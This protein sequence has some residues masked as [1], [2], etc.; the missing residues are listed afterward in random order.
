[1]KVLLAL[2]FFIFAAIQLGLLLGILHY[3]K[4]ESKSKPNPYWVLALITSVT[5]LAFFAVGL[6]NTDDIQRVPPIF[7]PANTLF[8]AAAILQGLFFYSFNHP[9][10]KSLKWA[11]GVSIICYGIFFEYL[12]QNWTFEARTI[13]VAST[14]A[15]I[16]AWQIRE[17]RVVNRNLG[18]QQLRYFQYAAIG[19][20]LFLAPRL[21]VL[22]G[23]SH[24]INKMEQLPQ[25]LIIFTFGQI[26]MNTLSFIAIWGYWSEKLAI[27]NRQTESENL[28]YKKLLDERETLISSLLKANKSSTT[29]ALTA[30]I[31][32]EINQPLGA[33][34]INSE[35]LQ[36][37]ISEETVD[38]EL[39]KRL[40]DDIS[41]DNMRAARIIRILKTIFS[42]KYD[43]VPDQV[44]AAEVIESVILL[45]K[46][47][48]S[49]KQIRVEVD[50]PNS[51]NIPM[52][53]GEAQQIF[54]NLINNSVQAFQSGSK[55][56][57]I[58]RISGT[59]DS[60][61]IRIRSEDNGPGVTPERVQN[62]FDL[63][64]GSKREGMGLGLWLCEYIISRH[65]G[66]I[67][68][69]STYQGGAAFEIT[70]S[71]TE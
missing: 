33:I 61:K 64:S 50:I 32:H 11:L 1:M 67:R 41:K 16:L 25:L 17:A 65:G 47:D 40:A 51:L 4:G 13:F 23:T 68:F 53:F 9:V 27:D 36:K 15:I 21:L 48:L 43:A 46:S 37:K 12:R 60:E 42:E 52:S 24:P 14:Y 59:E 10:S 7:T 57:R 69:D 55:P 28:T 20:A 38:R 30:S 29:G 62:L 58:M 54:L 35:Y 56:E 63:F 71:K 8:Y 44:S 22:L 39:I 6:L 19:E 2:N 3:L 49:E 45:S 70:F 26:L 18:L 5:G 31:A 66:K 34:Q